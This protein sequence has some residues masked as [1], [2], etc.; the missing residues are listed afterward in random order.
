MNRIS[1]ERSNSVRMPFSARGVVAAMS[2]ASWEQK[3]AGGW[4]II[5]LSVI[6]IVPMLPGF[7][8]TSIDLSKRLRPP[9]T[10]C[11]L[12]AVLGTDEVGRDV[13]PRL[14]IGLRTSIILAILGSIIGAV[15]G[16]SL[17]LIAAIKR[18]IVDDAVVSITDIQAALPFYI[19]AMSAVAIFGRGDAIFIVIV[20][21]YGWERYARLARA[22]TLALKAA[23]FIWALKG[24]G[25][26]PL[27]IYARHLLPNIGNPLLVNFALTFPKILL[28]EST[29]SFLGIGI[30][31]PNASLGVMIGEGRVFLLSAWWVALV[32]GVCIV[33]TALAASIFVESFRK[34][35]SES[36]TSARYIFVWNEKVEK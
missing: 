30:Q 25:A 16:I 5:C 29:L 9:C 26:H 14:I 27:R 17:G 6:L 20:G 8:A 21:L 11:G 10:D 23:P 13:L 34:K 1:Q 33:V 18:G 4:L 3:I 2:T 12:S 15:C 31:P 32:P 28:L 35:L 19:L 36:R 7:D 24:F 22:Q